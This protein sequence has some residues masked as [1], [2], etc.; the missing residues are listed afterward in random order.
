MST[1]GA[2]WKMRSSKFC[3]N[4]LK[5]IHDAVFNLTK[6]QAKVL[7]HYWKEET[8]AF[9]LSYFADVLRTPIL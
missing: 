7:Q 2:M 8:P 4:S 1:E 5:N 6:F 3:K 9:A